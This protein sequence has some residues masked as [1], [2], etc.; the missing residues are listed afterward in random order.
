MRAHTDHSSSQTRPRWLSLASRVLGM[1]L[2]ASWLVDAGCGSY[3]PLS[4][5]PDDPFDPGP[6]PGG[7][8]YGSGSGGMV[9]PP[10]PPPACDESLRRCPKDFLYRGTMAAPS[11]GD[12]RSVELRGDYRAGA[13]MAGDPFT[14]DAGTKTWRAT[15]EM[16]WNGRFLYKIRIVDAA[17]A[18]RWIADPE[19]PQSEPD[20]FGGMNSVGMGG[21][22]SKWTCGT[23]TPTCE[24]PST[25]SFDWRDAV[26]YFVFIDRFRD[27]NPGNN[28]P[29]T[30]GGLDP[31]T[32]WLGGDWAGVTQKIKDGY[33]TSLGVNALWLTVPMDNTD[34]TGLGDDGRKYTAYHGY[35]P[36]D[37]E[38]TEK[39]FGTM[40]ELRTLI[41]EAHKLGIKVLID[42][43]MNHVHKDAPIYAAHRSDG[44]F[45][46]LDLGGGKQC[47]CGAP[48]CGWDDPNKAKVCWFRDYLPDFN[49]N[50]A[51]ARTWSVD[52][53]IKWLTDY[54]IDGLRLDAVK[55]IEM[56]WLTDLRSRIIKDVESKTKEHVYLVGETYSG[57]R[58]AIRPFVDPCTKL[59]GQFD[60][61]LRAE[62]DGKVLLRQGK[63][64]DLRS[65]MDS[66][67]TFYGS[68]LM[69]TFIGN[70]DVPRSI[71]FAQNMPL[72]TNIW[73][74]GKDRNFG[75]SRPGVVAETAA[76]ER[77][78]LAMAILFTNR[79]V[80]LI[81]YGDEIGL[82]GAGDPDNRRMMDWN[83]A[84]Y[85]A[86][87]QLLL[88]RHKKLAAIRKAHAALR[89][90]SRTTISV[91]DDTWGYKMV[92]G[93]DLVY[94]LINRSDSPK[95]VGGLPANR[96][97][98]ALL[99]DSVT[100][101]EVSVPARGVRILVP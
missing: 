99:G 49:F 55:H 60:F 22:C 18:E 11:K 12:E 70:H 66:N 35:W 1:A 4:N 62:L 47:I 98:D 96:F 74:G 29:S 31:S 56:S 45:N 6:R 59:D 44:W 81:Y 30:E 48:E 40:A 15:I 46:P 101:P 13:W 37:L 3:S 64:Q 41:D 73:D 24:K 68:G 36:R 92:E 43:A 80:P 86:G 77:M 87:Q 71:H 14:W 88:D 26:M 94:V 95:N 76:Y 42:Y 33:F 82:P 7:S 32:N 100:G 53:A 65:F 97:N 2:L 72:W 20:G 85:N 89:Y 28:L 90:G 93:A 51:A 16:P 79:G 21:T 9:N 78:A 67:T 58:D 39:R 27:G 25:G 5:T 34:G 50:N 61:P 38:K 63:M 23:P 83:T 75:S 10:D 91:A 57:S 54:G 84:G 52:N 8:Q 19:N 17:G 69:S